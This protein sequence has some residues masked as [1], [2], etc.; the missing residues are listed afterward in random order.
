MNIRIDADVSI[1]QNDPERFTVTEY[2]RRGFSVLFRG[3]HAACA[4]FVR[5][6][7]ELQNRENSPY[8][9]MCRKPDACRNKGYCPLD[10]TCG[11]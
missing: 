1:D 9:E 7:P 6:N 4:N 5:A 10:P 8:G 11:D 2:T 3:T